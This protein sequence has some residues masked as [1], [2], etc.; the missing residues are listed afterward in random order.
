MWSPEDSKWA[1]IGPFKNWK[2]PLGSKHMFK[3]ESDRLLDNLGE[4]SFGCGLKHLNDTWKWSGTTIMI[5][6]TTNYLRLSCNAVYS[7]VTFVKRKPKWRNSL[8]KLDWRL[9]N[10]SKFTTSFM[11]CWGSSAINWHNTA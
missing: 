4:E 6:S 9:A 11:L 7:C 3:C 10:I 2:N 1:C 5:W 8:C